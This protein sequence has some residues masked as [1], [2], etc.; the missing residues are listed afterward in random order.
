MKYERRP[1]R[2]QRLAA[3]IIMG[4]GVAL[5]WLSQMPLEIIQRFGGHLAP[6]GN[7]EILASISETWLHGGLLVG[8]GLLFV[9]GG[10][11]LVKPAWVTQPVGW[12][13]REVKS[14]CSLLPKDLN[15]FLRQLA[16]WPHDRVD[17]WALLVTMLLSLLL[18]IS[19]LDR[20]MYHDESYTVLTWASGTLRY[21]LEDYHLPNNH[22]FHT[23]LVGISYNLI[24]SQPWAV[25]L[26]AFI[27]G[28]LLIPAGYG[29]TRRWY[30]RG[31]AL[32]A[33]FF[34]GM[35]PILT[36]YATNARGYTLFMLFSLL[37]FWLAAR[38]VR[39][40]NRFEWALLALFG[41]LGF[42]TVPMMLYPFGAVCVWIFL[43]ILF[44]RK[45]L[46]AYGSRGR[47]LKYLFMVGIAAI[48]LT[49]LMYLPVLLNTGTTQLFN[50]PFIAPLSAE[51]FWPTLFI[52]RLPE[53]YNELTRSLDV[54]GQLV[55]ILGLVLSIALNKKTGK[56]SI[57]GLAAVLLWAI[58]ILV[59]R[60]PNAWARTWSFLFPMIFIWAAAG[61]VQLISFLKFG[62]NALGVKRWLTAGTS[63]VVLAGALIIG[64]Q[65][66]LSLCPGVLCESGE[67]ES[68]V[69]YLMPKLQKT[70]VV[71]VESPSNVVFWYYFTQYG[72]S[73]DHFRTDIPFERAYILVRP[74]EEQSLD[75]VMGV[76][77]YS[78]DW[79]DMNTLELVYTDR[80]ILTYQ[81]D[82]NL[83]RVRYE[84][85]IK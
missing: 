51:E 18:R 56:S 5:L 46:E 82:A 50:N 47:L 25:R 37:I 17:G 67:E 75:T 39:T 77:G 78:Q 79:F 58:P 70:D 9:F 69:L 15:S 59:W 80:A 68:T 85:G 33:A 45:A 10:V 23:L 26:P 66:R 44:D 73:R 21:M 74:A 48:I 57:H 30:S 27:A 64:V 11:W 28:M 1:R 40:N 29:L 55:L 63:V 35:A 49:G 53:T 81:V 16:G 41:A 52:S 7:L 14:F 42:W 84:Y 72:I 76:N 22:I 54:M 61:W 12:F 34:V 19:L 32:L 20:P 71:L 8:G 31:T 83:E 36:D 6:D 2:F 65:H 4:I 60:K 38:L 43:S 62:E 24:G 13:A 3:I